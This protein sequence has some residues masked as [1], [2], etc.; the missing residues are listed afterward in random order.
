[1]TKRAL[2]TGGAGF[3]GSNLVKGLASRDYEVY[4]VDD[5][6]NGYLAFLPDDLAK[7]RRWLT[8]FD[9]QILLN[10]IRNQK[11]DFV[12][13][14]AAQPRVSFSVEKPLETHDSNVTK[15]MK[16]LEACRGNTE[17][18][19]F[20]S[21]S[22]VYGNSDQIPTSTVARLDPQSPYALQK[23][24]IENYLSLYWKLYKFDSV[25]LRFFNVFGPNQIGSSPYST[26]VSSWLNAIL[27]QN[28]MRS[29]GDGSQTRDMCYV[30]NVVDAC[31]KAAEVK[32]PLA[33]VAL[34][35]GCGESVSNASILSYLLKKFPDSKF[36]SAPWR[37]GDV[38]DTLADISMT[39]CMVGYEPSVS[40][41]D[42]LDR[43]IQWYVENWNLISHISNQ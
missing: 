19:I 30:D 18:F 27:K 28:S 4:I 26:A 8:S 41:W 20:A 29:D 32:K 24:I 6:S 1:M 35:V 43:T 15:T 7:N 12:F 33:G 31:I 21:S 25:S 17:K 2:V 5:L 34:N 36:H 39:R 3:I 16:L 40:F 23:L 42:G 10:D 14:L 11:F 38:K 9:D 22:S 13:H 37:A